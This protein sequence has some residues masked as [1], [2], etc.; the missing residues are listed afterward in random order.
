MTKTLSGRTALVTGVS[1][2]LGG[3]VAR[4]CIAAGA[5]VAGTYNT[6][7]S[8]LERLGLTRAI[9]TDLSDERSVAECFE[10]VRAA[11]GTPEIVVHCAGGFR[12]DGFLDATSV[13]TWNTMIRMNLTSSFLVLRQSLREMHDLSYGRIILVSALSALAPGKGA[14]AY[15][16][17]KAGVRSLVELA[18]AE[19]PGNGITINALAPGTIDTPSNRSD[20][21]DADHTR[22]TSPDS[23]AES[24][25]YLCT[26]AGG[27][28]SGAVIP[29]P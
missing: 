28:T 26:E 11:V 2:A 5:K 12:S 25:V 15:K 10:E 4:H 3:S 14:G 17:S 16:V 24:V 27:A 20:M 9:K 7:S 22:W 13:E 6:R 8:G 21:P 29:F 19:R 23:I 18:S 1:G